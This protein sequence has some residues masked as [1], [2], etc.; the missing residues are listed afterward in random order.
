MKLRYLVDTDWVIDY[1]NGQAGIVSDLTNSGRKN[2]AS[3]SFPSLNCLKECF[4]SQRRKGA[5]QDLHNFL[6]TVRIVPLDESVCEIF[7]PTNAPAPRAKS[8]AP[9]FETAHLPPIR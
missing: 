3:R 9:A 5:E 8:R 2:W 6:R 1:L 7:G 4:N